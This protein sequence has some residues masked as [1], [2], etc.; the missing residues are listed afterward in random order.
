MTTEEVQA[1]SSQKEFFMYMYVFMYIQ[2][3]N[4]SQITN[5]IY[6]ANVKMQTCVLTTNIISIQWLVE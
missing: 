3:Y 6:W 2:I 1:K 4:I 5:L